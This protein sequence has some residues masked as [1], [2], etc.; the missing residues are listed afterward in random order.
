MTGCEQKTNAT[1]TIVYRL[2][3]SRSSRSW[4]PSGAFGARLPRRYRSMGL[5]RSDLCI[6][7][8][9]K[10]PQA[11]SERG[12]ASHRLSPISHT[13]CPIGKQNPR[14]RRLETARC[15]A[16]WLHR[17]ARNFRHPAAFTRMA[18]SPHHMVL[19][20]SLLG[21]LPPSSSTLQPQNDNDKQ[22]GSIRNS[23]GQGTRRPTGL[24]GTSYR[25]ADQRPTGQREAQ[26]P[27]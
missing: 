14:N 1:H 27:S 19:A 7:P 8:H 3:V 11:M 9:D 10:G 23:S 15:D 6:A 16:R 26:P 2:E 25:K 22:A 12:I 5:V 13:S 24:G 20:I 17:A 18:V 21:H 4:H